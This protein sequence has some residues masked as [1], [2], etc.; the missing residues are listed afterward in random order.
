MKFSELIT[1]LT[2]SRI[3]NP[4]DSEV[5]GIAYDSRQVQAGFVFVAMKGGSHDGHAFIPAA[6]KSGACGIVAEHDVDHIPKGIGLAIVP[7]GRRAMGEMAAPF[8]DY[9]SR[10]MKLIGVTGT[11]GK[12][13]VTH[14]IQSIFAASGHKAGLIGTLGA[15]IGDELIPTE[16]TTP[17]SVDI[18]RILRRMADRGVDAA[19]ME[20]SSHGLHQGRTLGCEFDCGV[21]TNIARDHLDYHL[22]FENYLDAKLILFRDYPRM[23][24][25]RFTAV[26]NADDPS[27]DVVRQATAGDAL[28]F[29]IDSPADVKAET[30]EVT[31]KS[32]G[33]DLVYQNARIRAK[34][35]IGGAFNVYNALSAAAAGLALG[36]GLA[37]VVMGLSHAKAVP[38]RFEAV[39]CGQDFG[40]LVD[41]AH[42]PDELENVLKTARSLV[43]DR[44]IAVFGCG[45]DRDRGKRPIMGGIGAQLADLVVVTSDNP[46]TED[47][48]AIIAQILEGIPAGSNAR[49]DVVPDR[50]EAIREAIAQARA[51]DIV[52]IAGKGHE[53]Y[54]IFADR[55]IHFDDREIAREALC[56]ATV[57]CE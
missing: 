43:H 23:S 3:A 46:R 19:A 26:V 11:S 37:D 38:G 53:D 20:A 42:T 22:T 14:L 24:D 44:L 32:V 49:V 39:E 41:Y 5:T 35:N 51:G 55:T 31:D 7:N 1:N 54:Q 47:P 52:V 45:G 9:P 21:F 4:S 15:R 10:S 18:Q 12:T 57:H 13:T 28:T 40:V 16:H 56:E 48:N 17:E 50:R 34:L 25:K 6:I 29:G 8:Y 30:V 27:A 36:V 2:E 33:F